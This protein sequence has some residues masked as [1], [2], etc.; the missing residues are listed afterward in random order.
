MI[1]RWRGGERRP[2]P[3]VEELPLCA[4][5]AIAALPGNAKARPPDFR[6]G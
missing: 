6:I 5:P 1:G 3:A 2:P 4:N